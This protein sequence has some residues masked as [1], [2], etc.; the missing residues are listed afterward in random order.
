MTSPVD[1]KCIS[2][3][4]GYAQINVHGVCLPRAAG[5]PASISIVVAMNE[6]KT[7][8]VLGTVSDVCATN[9]ARLSLGVRSRS[10]VDW[11]IGFVGQSE[12]GQ[13]VYDAEN[14]DGVGSGYPAEDFNRVGH[15]LGIMGY[16]DHTPVCREIFV[17]VSPQSQ[18]KEFEET[19]RGRVEFWPVGG[20]GAN[21]FQCVFQV[22]LEKNAT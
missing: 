3:W 17:P 20:A 11:Q 6:D 19:I 8:R 1:C 13:I 18:N 4:R 5:C 21:L 22:F 9:A 7:S 2:E 15:I 12:T 14:D 10:C 16:G